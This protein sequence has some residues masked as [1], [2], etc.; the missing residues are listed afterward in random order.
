MK[1]KIAN[2]L[3]PCLSHKQKVIKRTEGATPEHILGVP[4]TA[5]SSIKRKAARSSEM[6]INFLSVLTEAYP[7]IQYSQI[8]IRMVYQIMVV[9]FKI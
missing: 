3:K 2:D 5:S 6:W 7:K 9:T 4:V 8:C 1:H